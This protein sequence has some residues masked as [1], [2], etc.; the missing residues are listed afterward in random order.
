MTTPSDEFDMLHKRMSGAL[1]TAAERERAMEVFWRARRFFIGS[2]AL[3]IIL[4]VGIA[5]AYLR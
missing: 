5:T 1:Q 3:N 2:V 4:L